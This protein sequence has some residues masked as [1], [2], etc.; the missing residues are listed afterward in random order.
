MLDNIS[1]EVWFAIVGA[2]GVAVGGFSKHLLGRR[3]T[4]TNEFETVVK[5]NTELRD[6]LRREVASLKEENAKT[7]EALISTQADLNVTRV[8]LLST[9]NELTV[10]VVRIRDLELQ[11]KHK[12][13]IIANLLNKLQ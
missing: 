7:K 9:K 12:D 8:E 4:R 6:E 3:K 13:D 11:L 2:L 10:A 5:M 1:T